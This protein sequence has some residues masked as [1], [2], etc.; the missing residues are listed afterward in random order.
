MPPEHPANRLPAAAR[1]SAILEAAGL[2]FVRHGLHGT[3]TRELARTC[4]ITE[5][6]L[7]RHFP[8]KVA[9]F[10]AVLEHL[11]ENACTVVETA[12]GE[13]QRRRGREEV[14]A[15]FLLADSAPDV[16]EATAL[17]R[18]ARPRLDALLGDDGAA[19]LRSD[20]GDL[21]LQRLWPD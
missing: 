4:G 17:L 6:V 2:A 16:P 9:L 3:T 12:S 18:E 7:Y 15:V 8:G 10:L 5:P 11:L 1:R 20:I 21:V 13:T 19:T 14:A